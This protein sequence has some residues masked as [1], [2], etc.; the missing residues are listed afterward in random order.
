MIT[1]FTID[2]DHLTHQITIEN[3]KEV[4]EKYELWVRKATDKE[5]STNR[6]IRTDNTSGVTGVSFH[7]RSGKW[8]AF[9]VN[10][11]KKVVSLGYFTDKNNAIVARLNGEIKYYGEFAPQKHLY[12]QY[13]INAEI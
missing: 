4:Q 1:S 11:Q 2:K 13:N 3:F 8:W 9:V 7:K 10:D 5:N 6:K 12:E